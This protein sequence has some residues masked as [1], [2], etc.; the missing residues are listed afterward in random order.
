MQICL[1]K[2]FYAILV[3]YFIFYSFRAGAK[4]YYFWDAQILV[5]YDV[6]LRAMLRA[7]CDRPDQRDL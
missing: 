6:F 1:E 2:L 3:L 7:T 5:L 4:V